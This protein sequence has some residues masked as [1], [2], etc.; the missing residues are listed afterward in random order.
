MEVLACGVA[1]VRILTVVC[2]AIV[3][4]LD[5]RDLKINKITKWLNCQIA[6]WLYIVGK[7]SV[8]KKFTQSLIHF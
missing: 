2:I 3:W 8:V 7:E 6:K 5:L 1:A 4:N